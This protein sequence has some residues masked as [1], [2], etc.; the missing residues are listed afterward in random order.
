MA[1]DTFSK[2]PAFQAWLKEVYVREQKA[3][4]MF[5]PKNNTAVEDWK[6]ESGWIA[7]CE[8]LFLKLGGK[9]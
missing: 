4:P 2:D 7:G 9:K 5:H 8:F 1:A 3:P 6:Y